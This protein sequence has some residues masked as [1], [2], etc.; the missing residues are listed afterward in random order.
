MGTKLIIG[1]VLIFLAGIAIAVCYLATRNPRQPKW[2]S[3]SVI[4]TVILPL[5][6]GA[7]FMGPMFVGQ[8]LFNRESLSY[9]DIMVALSVFV[10]GMIILL[11]MRIP[12]RVAS[13]DALRSAAEMQ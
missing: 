11:L 4:G 6:V 2:A 7:L 13:Y 9:S 10:A 12:K 5:A 8:A 1:V 3:D